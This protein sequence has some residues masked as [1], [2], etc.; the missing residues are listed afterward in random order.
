MT[1]CFITQSAQ[2]T[3][4]KAQQKKRRKCVERERKSKRTRVRYTHAETLMF[5]I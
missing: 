1:S 4:E 3:T 5:D 2:N